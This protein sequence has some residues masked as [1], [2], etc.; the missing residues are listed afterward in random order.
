MNY[1]A[2]DRR[3]PLIDLAHHGFHERSSSLEELGRD[4]SA[5]FAEQINKW[6]FRNHNNTLK[7]NVV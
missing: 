1:L 7:E 6:Q 4:Q 3:R 5:Q 2:R